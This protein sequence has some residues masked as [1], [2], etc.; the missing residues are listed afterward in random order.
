MANDE[1]F[2]C[3]VR[4]TFRPDKAVKIGNEGFA[5]YKKN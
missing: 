5:E 3:E 4:P 2:D 1:N